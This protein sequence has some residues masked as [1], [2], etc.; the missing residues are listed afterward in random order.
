MSAPFTNSVVMLR[1][2]GNRILATYGDGYVSEWCNCTTERGAKARLTYHAKR[3][4]FAV[5]GSIAQVK[6]G[7]A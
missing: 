4:G 1:R 5:T 3:L 7:V 2:E 6:G